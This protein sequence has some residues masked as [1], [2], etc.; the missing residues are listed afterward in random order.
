MN[1]FDCLITTTLYSKMTIGGISYFCN[2]LK[3]EIKGD[4]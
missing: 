2:L 4:M 3:I 1:V